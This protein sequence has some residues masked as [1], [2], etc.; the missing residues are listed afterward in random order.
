[1]RAVAKIYGAKFLSFYWLTAKLERYTIPRVSGVVCVSTHTQRLVERHARATYLIPNAVDEAFFEIVRR[2]PEVP[3]VICVG[4]IDRNKN[5]VLLIDALRPLAEEREFKLGFFGKVS[6]VNDPGYGDEFERRTEEH[7]WCEHEGFAGREA[8]REAMGAATAL[9]LPSK[10]DNCPMVILEAMAA[11][12]PV[13][14]SKIGGIPDLI[15]DGVTGLFCD[16]TD[17]STIERAVR[18]LLDEP[19]LAANI[20]SAAKAKAR[21]NYRPVQ[22]AQR[23]YDLYKELV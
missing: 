23:H 15:E 5:Q 1:M 13:I 10:E 20:G 19:G 9:I 12:I 14:A 17:G 7:S 22:V 18:R 3:T 11:G 2:V 16:P 8:L 4:S 6:G 21:A